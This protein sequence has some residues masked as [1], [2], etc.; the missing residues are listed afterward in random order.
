MSR[1]KKN[2]TILKTIF[3]NPQSNQISL[4]TKLSQSQ[5]KYVVSITL[6]VAI[7]LPFSLSRTER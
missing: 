5:C 3:S 6:Q 2:T 7:L 4:Q 1:E